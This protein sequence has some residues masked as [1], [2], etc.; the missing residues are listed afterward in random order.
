MRIK[1]TAAAFMIAAVLPLESRADVVT[2]WNKTTVDEIRKLGLGPNPASR[3]LAIAHIAAYEA[4]NTLSKTHEPYR[5]ALPVN[6]PA[7]PDAAAASAFH[8]ALVLLFPAE[9]AA[10]DA[11]YEQSLAAIPDDPARANG[12]QLGEASAVAIFTARIADGS[13]TTSTY[14]GSTGPGKWRPT[15]SLF[16]AALEPGWRFVVPFAL[17]KPEQ[18][19]PPPPPAVDSAA[20][21]TAYLETQSVG[22]SDSSS[23]T[24]EQTNIANFWKQPTH[25]PVNAIA[26]SVSKVR[27]LTLDQNVR[28]FALLNITI[29]DTRIAV[30]DAKYEYGYWR[31]VTAI[32]TTT[33]YGN[34]DAVPD[35]TWTPLLETPNH[36]E[37]PSGHSTTGGG[38]L[39]A[40]G[41]FFGSDEVS[42]AVGS[43]S[44]P[45]VTRGFDRFSDAEQENANSRIYG[46]IHFRFSNETGIAVGHQIADYV[47]TNS[48]KELP[49]PPSSGGEGGVAGEVGEAGT[50][51]GAGTAGTGGRAGAAA[52]GTG[53]EVRG[54]GGDAG[55]ATPS[56]GKPSGGAPSASGAPNRPDPGT[57][58]TNSCSVGG[59]SSP[60]GLFGATLALGAA[61]FVVRRRRQ[62]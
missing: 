61:L 41:T 29:A 10:L 11:A 20:F 12:I 53:D 52:G 26:R 49:P 31:P 30:W 51:N 15:P 18:F 14:P 28:L 32:N 9:K 38:G 42:F 13:A 57:D 3:A 21:A 17:S 37:Y 55:A 46:G 4:V 24:A 16:Q 22:K 2:D 54:A 33:D 7:S 48:L 25:V 23:R 40:L 35:S 8:L 34:A 58:Q 39:R 43:D 1:L 62:R 47:F 56:G 44:A 36:P 27:N 19:R 59:P 50:S 60:W 6:L 45:G 5:A